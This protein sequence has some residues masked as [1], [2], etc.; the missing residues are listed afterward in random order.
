VWL[1]YFIPLAEV[2]APETELKVTAIGCVD[3]DC[4][5]TVD[6]FTMDGA[7]ISSYDSAGTLMDSCTVSTA[8]DDFDGCL[9]VRAPEDG[10][11]GVTP[12]AGYADYTLLSSSPEVFESEVHGTTYVW[13]FVP[14]AGEPEAPYSPVETVQVNV[15]ICVDPDCADTVNTKT[16]FGATVSSY[17][18]DGSLLDSCTVTTVVDRTVCN[19][20]LP[21]DGGWYDIEP[22]AGY[23]GYVLLTDTPDIFESEMHG[24][25]YVWYFAP[26]KD[27]A[28]P[29]PT[30]APANTAAPKPAT[31][32]GLPST[33]SGLAM[34]STLL[35]AFA[36]MPFALAGAAFVANRVSKR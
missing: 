11:Y 26:E 7:T 10:S 9:V 1:W 34:D 12:S 33:G 36:A 29:P 27:N 8:A 18:P 14:P 13:Y 2:P 5:N 25:I 22:A 16:M 35:V 19:L 30:Q 3:A 20:V 28:F 17:M 21:P 31:V 15:I 6:I 4:T 32:T 24:P 23:E